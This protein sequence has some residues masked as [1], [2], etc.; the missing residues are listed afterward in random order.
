MNKHS[1]GCRILGRE[2]KGGESTSNADMYRGGG[3]VLLRN[4]IGHGAVSNT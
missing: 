1:S 2:S 3:K 4:L